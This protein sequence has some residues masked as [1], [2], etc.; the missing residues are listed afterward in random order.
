MTVSPNAM[1][2]IGIT[3]S[4]QPR[5]LLSPCLLILIPQQP[6]QDLSTRTLGN[7]VN[8]LNTAL[9]PLVS[10]LVLLDVPLDL[11]FDDR[12]IVFGTYRLRLDDVCLGQ[13]ACVI[14]WDGDYRTVSDSRVIEKASFELCRSDLKTLQFRK[15]ASSTT[16]TLND[17]GSL[18]LTLMSSFILSTIQIC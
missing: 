18:T 2:R 11:A 15:L 10:C 3:S 12:V 4:S 5:A 9:Q 7:H 14:V 16:A 6:S 13:L 1:T 17:I 8:K